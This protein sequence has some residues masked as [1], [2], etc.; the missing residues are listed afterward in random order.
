MKY[1]KS[2]KDPELYYSIN[3]NGEKRWMF[4]HKYYDSLGKRKEKKK[5]GF[6]TEKEAY[7]ALL[8]VKTNTIRGATKQVEHSN[9]TIATWF[10]IWYETHEADW[11]PTSR[12]QREMAIRLQ[13]KPL[14]GHFKL[15]ELDKTTY[16]RAF[17]NPL[18]KKYKV[19]TVK[20]FHR[21]F[22]IGINAA[23]DDE[24]LPRNRFNKI[25]I[26]DERAELM[27][28]GSNLNF[29][30]ANE[31]NKL[32]STAKELENITNYT[33]F[34]LL[35]YTG[36]RRGEACGLQWNNIDFTKK[37]LTVER[38][39]DNKGVRSPKTNNSYRTILIDDILVKQLKKYKKWCK[40]TKLLFG[41][42]LKRDDF[43][44]ISYQTGKPITDS[45]ICYALRRIIKKADL[46]SITPHG[47]RH[48]HATL[49]LSQG[50]RGASVKV[51]AERLGNTPQMIL[52]IYGHT[53]MEL[54]EETV[55]LFSE[56]LS[57]ANSGANS[58]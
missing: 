10:D 58:E 30:E 55:Q 34:L 41:Y 38:T 27:A 12:Q 56:S 6:F 54:E 33:I 42:H 5:R 15:Q 31:L 14:L 47:L 49:L 13:I 26:R 22:K 44:F 9:Y 17:I 48:T 40:E 18:L 19:E 24:I 7:Q 32:L 25:T 11:K 53:F 45:S 39:R 29:L 51:V 2:K 52:D 36:L 43:I 1:Y 20:L 23:V 3:D 16:K 35:A 57:G 37:T 8:E 21:L 28:S 46:K 4:R 50:K